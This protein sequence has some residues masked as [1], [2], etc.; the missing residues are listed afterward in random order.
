MATAPEISSE[1][2]LA[3]GVVSPVTEKLFGVCNVSYVEKIFGREREYRLSLPRNFDALD[4]IYVNIE[5]PSRIT[6]CSLRV[7]GTPIRRE[8][9]PGKVV[10]AKE[11]LE[12][13]YDRGDAPE[14][15]LLPSSFPLWLVRFQVLY[16]YFTLD[17]PLAITETCIRVH[18]KGRRFTE[19]IQHSNVRWGDWV[20]VDNLIKE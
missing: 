18:T 9:V 7:D 8:L 1:E 16:L 15:N 4:G 12:T 17:R 6:E 19:N 20:I 14:C 13:L 11:L 5:L 3:T 10:P 2:F